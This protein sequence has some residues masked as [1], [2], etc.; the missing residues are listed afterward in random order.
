MD[1]LL[2]FDRPIY[3]DIVLNHFA[4]AFY[5]FYLAF[6][7][8]CCQWPTIWCVIFL[9]ISRENTAQWQVSWLLSSL[10]GYSLKKILT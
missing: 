6:I 9:D 8:P 10:L 2:P 4:V 3:L 5:Y 7:F 1:D